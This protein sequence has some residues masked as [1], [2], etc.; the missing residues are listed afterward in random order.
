MNVKI[1]RREMGYGTTLLGYALL[2]KQRKPYK[3]PQFEIIYDRNKRML[4]R[5]NLVFMRLL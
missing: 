4:F 3:K 2:E 5:G 1:T